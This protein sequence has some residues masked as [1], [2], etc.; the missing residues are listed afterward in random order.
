MTRQ[1][2]RFVGSSLGDGT[3][4]ERSG[5]VK[6][7]VSRDFLPLFYMIQT[8]LGACSNKL[9]YFQ[10]RLWIWLRYSNFY[11][12]VRFQGIGMTLQS[13]IL[14][15]EW[16]WGGSRK[17]NIYKKNSAVG[18]TPRSMIFKITKNLHCV[19]LCM[20]PQSEFKNYQKKTQRCHSHHGIR[21]TNFSKNSTEWER[22]QNLLKEQSGKNLLGVNPW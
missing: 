1:D 8:N 11:C 22:N 14:L 13:P 5:R 21:N 3:R 10:F 9:K 12:T 17:K 4:F 18:G 19:Q 6:G 15:W 7:S 20:T 2:L 16:L